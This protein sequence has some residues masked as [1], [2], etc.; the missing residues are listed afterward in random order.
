MMPD[1]HEEQRTLAGGRVVTVL[2]CDEC[3]E[4]RVPG[5]WPDCRKA[6]DH[7]P[8]H[9]FDDALDSYVDVQILERKDPRCDGV[10]WLGMRGVTI[11]SRSQRRALMREKNLQFGNQKFDRR[12]DGGIKYLDMRRR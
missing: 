2:I 6:G 10:N 9:G 3:G 1:Y 12:G 4:E 5:D 8:G 7:S 11:H